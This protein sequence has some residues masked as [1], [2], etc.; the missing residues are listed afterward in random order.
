V[1][2]DGMDRMKVHVVGGI[3]ERYKLFKAGILERYK[4]VKE[5]V[6]IRVT[7]ENI[8]RRLP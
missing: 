6:I 5:N 7:I 3:L 4:L 1:R 2:F 8:A